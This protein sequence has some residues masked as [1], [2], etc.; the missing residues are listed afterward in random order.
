MGCTNAD[1]VK[2]LATKY[3][4]LFSSQTTTHTRLNDIR[5]VDMLISDR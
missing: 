2:H 4:T 5:H 3:R 1:R